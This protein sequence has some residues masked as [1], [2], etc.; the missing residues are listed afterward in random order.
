M[1]KKIGIL[2]LI[3]LF[4]VALIGINLLLNSQNEMKA[5]S[6]RD[7]GQNI[8]KE[9]TSENPKEQ[10]TENNSS[11]ENNYPKKKK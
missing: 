10:D 2:I 11:E 5:E 1:K 6:I 8:A 7:S 3:V 9:E 4:I